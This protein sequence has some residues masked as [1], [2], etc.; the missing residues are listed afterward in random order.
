MSNTIQSVME[1][2]AEI[3]VMN[4]M[5]LDNLNQSG[6]EGVEKVAAAAGEMTRTQ[7]R[8]ESFAFKII[9]VEPASDDMLVPSLTHDK[10]M[11]YATLEPDSPGA[12][13]V[14]F[15]TVAEGEYL[16]GSRY[17]IPLARIVTK[18]YQKDLAE[19]RTY[20]MDLRK[21]I[22]DNSVKDGLAEIDGKFIELCNDILDDVTTITVDGTNY[23][24]QSHTGKVQSMT[25]SGGLNKENLAEAGKM[26][27]EG[28]LFEG[29][30]RKYRLRT[31]VVL[32]NDV[33]A[34]DLLKLDVPEIGDANVDAMFKGGLQMKKVLG[35][36]LIYT[37][38]GDLVP[39]GHAYF[40]A[41]PEFLGKAYYLEDWTMYM[42]KEAFMIEM[43]SYWLGGMAIGNVAGVCRA[44]FED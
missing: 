16:Y 35:L 18:K 23:D 3:K 5:V 13:W 24:V 26:M 41:A 12:K 11:I 33:T 27:L 40:F 14:S 25:F 2:S 8:E 15:Q 37:I 32:M 31:H 19:L 28:S 44:I 29:L 17:V 4:N 9:P 38:K 36:N 43:F 6:S 20:D 34:Q 7:L 10:P 22:T 21:Y 1:K 42:K 39:N 30:N